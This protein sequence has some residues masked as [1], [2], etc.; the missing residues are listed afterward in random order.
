M[1]DKNLPKEYQHITDYRKIPRH[2]LNPKIPKGRGIVKWQ[3]FVKTIPEQYELIKKH[4]KNQNKVE[5][6]LLSD[7]QADYLNQ[8]IQLAIYNNSFVSI[9]YWRDG[10]ILNIQGYIKNINE[11][12]EGLQITNEHGTD[13]IW[14]SFYVLYNIEEIP[15]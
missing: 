1:I 7:T 14:L 11:L 13:S 15:T 12:K 6:P 2:L 9:D 10:H 5:R 8:Q 3:P 4:E